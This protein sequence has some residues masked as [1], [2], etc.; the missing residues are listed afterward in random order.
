M[1]SKWVRL[2]RSPMNEDRTTGEFIKTASIDPERII[3]TVDK[4]KKDSKE[5]K[6]IQNIL[7]YAYNNIDLTVLCELPN[8][9]E[10]Y[11]FFNSENINP[12]EIC[13]NWDEFKSYMHQ[14]GIRINTCSAVA[15]ATS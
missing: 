13:E 6:E 4:I 3:E 1:E 8:I 14:K 10:N 15:E 9:E 7:S 11:H 5:Y 12:S 2:I